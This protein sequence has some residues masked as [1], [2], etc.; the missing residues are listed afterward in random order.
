MVFRYVRPQED[1]HHQGSYSPTSRDDAQHF[2]GGLL[3]LLAKSE[4][5][6]AVECLRTLLDE[7]LLADLRDWMAH[8]LEDRRKR[9]ADFAPWNPSNV[10]EFANNHEVDPKTD[11]ELFGIG[12]KRFFEL[13]LDVEK[14]E[15]SL[16]RELHHE[17]DEAELRKWLH[18]KLRERSRG[19][20]TVPEEVEID[21]KQRPDI[22]LENPRTAPVSVEVKWA[23]KWTP[24]Q[25]LERLENQLIGQYLRAYDSRYGIYVLGVIKPV[26]DHWKNPYDGK[27]MQFEELV[28]LIRS[29]ARELSL[30]LAD[31][32]EIEVFGIDFREPKR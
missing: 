27:R 22:R 14:A 11:R 12:R 31:V 15:N 26:R 6:D 1:I 29:R 5:P 3:D 21:L 9:D 2:R 24:A 10:R 32:D 13:K 7:P 19:R 28:E 25:L 30:S 16:R 4:S 20:Y 17:Y 18:R 8:L 23:E